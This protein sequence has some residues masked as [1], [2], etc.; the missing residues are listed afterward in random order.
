M[1]LNCKSP[2]TSNLEIAI[3]QNVHPT[4][5]DIS[6]FGGMNIYVVY[7]LL[8]RLTQIGDVAQFDAEEEVRERI[9]SG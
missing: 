2:Y 4:R 9:D 5:V 1:N 8:Y 7:L 6:N 3:V